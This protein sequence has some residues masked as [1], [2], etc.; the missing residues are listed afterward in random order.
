MTHAPT[1]AV[2]LAWNDGPRVLGLLERLRSSISPPAKVV[3][4]DN[5]SMDG[6]AAAIE[7]EYPEHE[8]IVLPG[9]AGFSRAANIGIRR[10][11]EL[12]AGWIWL[13]NTDIDL[14]DDALARLHRAARPQTSA[15]A[16]L[17]DSGTLPVADRTGECGMVGATLLEPDGS[18]Q[19]CGGG[20]VSLWT[21]IARHER[22]D[23]GRCD[24]LSGACL[25]LRADM[26]R[27][28]GLFDEA[29]FFYWEDVDLGF[30]ARAGGWALRV[31]GDCMVVH[32]EGSSL[33]RWSDER[34]DHLFRGMI[35]FLDA[36]APFPRIAASVRL[37]HHT[38]TMLRHGR[39]AA[40]AGAW[41]AFRSQSRSPQHPSAP[42]FDPAGA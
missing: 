26:L 41:R 5:G 3:I 17:S 32:R 11:L 8:T 24:Y 42:A 10:A 13:L 18:V 36:R 14:P 2:V 4:V 27:E 39:R 22:F 40:I 37:L 15:T 34:W 21:G 9:N 30:R 33:G 28:I 23:R 38:A 25:L 6:T 12:G 31:A 7:R 1:V 29:Y 16:P 19:A 20:R 35:R